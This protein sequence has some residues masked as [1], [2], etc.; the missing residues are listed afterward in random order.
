MVMV[1]KKRKNIRLP[2]AVYEYP[3]QLFSITIGTFKRRN[4]FKD[5]LIADKIISTLNSGPIAKQTDMFAYCLMPDHLHILISVKNGNLIEIIGG[6]K[7]FSGSLLR[8][9][10]LNGP[11]WQRGFYDHALR[12]DE[13][14]VKTTE[15]MVMN[16]VRAGLVNQWREYSFSWHKWM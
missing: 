4:L 13:D 14:I 15:Y 10:G 6:W 9:T 16:P 8:K 5:S 12:K 1:L 7:K 2:R 3:N 11:F